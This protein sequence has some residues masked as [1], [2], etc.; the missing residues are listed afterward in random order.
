MG[1]SSDRGLF[2]YGGSV[3]WEGGECLCVCKH[4]ACHCFSCV[5]VVCVHVDVCM[6]VGGC[7]HPCIH[8][9]RT[10][11]DVSCFLNH[12]LPCFVVVLLR[13][14]LSLSLNTFIWFGW[15]SEPEG[16]DC[17]HTPLSSRSGITYVHHR[18]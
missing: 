18:A 5:C 7:A 12:S 11:V 9:W 3:A 2:G 6:C 16:S 1:I 4:A 8:V 14:S 15:M 13:Q 17:L 10:E